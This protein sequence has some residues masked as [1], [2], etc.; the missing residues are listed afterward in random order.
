MKK[1]F[2]YLTMLASLLLMPAASTA[3]GNV[4]C[5]SGGA[6]GGTVPVLSQPRPLGH[7]AVLPLHVLPSQ[8]ARRAPTAATLL[9]PVQSRV[10]R[11]AVAAV[12]DLAGKKVMTYSTSSSSLGSGGGSSA[13]VTTATGDSIV[14]DG[15]YESGFKVK[16]AVDLSAK[17]VSIPVQTVASGISLGS[18]SGGTEVSSLYIAAQ[19]SGYAPDTAATIGGT[20]DDTGV[21]TLSKS[22]GIYVASGSFKNA[23][24]AL[25]SSAVIEPSNGTMHVTYYQDSAPAEDW[26][27]VIVQ[28][29][30]KAIAVKNFGNHGKT[31]NLVLND[32]GYFTVASQLAC[33]AGSAHGG[34]YYT[35]SIDDWGKGDKALRRNYITGKATPAEL[36]MGNWL[37]LSNSGYYTGK[38]ASA[39]IAYDNSAAKFTVPSL[40]VSGFNGTGTEADPYQVSVWDHLL[41]LSELANVGV[42]VDTLGAACAG[43]YYKLTADITAGTGL[44]PIGWPTKGYAFGG[45]FDG[46]NHT[47]SGLTMAS[48]EFSGLFGFI[49]KD[50]SVKNLNLAKVSIAGAGNYHGAVAGVTHGTIYNCHVAG[51]VA[52]TANGVGGIAGVVYGVAGRVE[53]C[54]FDGTVTGTNLLG[55]I[56]GQVYSDGAA[57][58][59]CNA[60]GT[61][62]FGRSRNSG[63]MAGGIAGIADQGSVV[64][65][66]YF[67]GTIKPST[68]RGSLL[69]GIAGK[70]Y[71]SAVVERCFAV[72]TIN[73]YYSAVGGVVG[74]LSATVRNCYAQGVITDENYFEG[75]K[76]TVGGLVGQMKG[77]IN[78]AGAY[79][80]AVL[81]NV[82]FT[83]EINV[84][85]PA[86]DGTLNTA[87]V[88]GQ[89]ADSLGNVY[90]DK[91]MVDLGSASHG[92]TTAQL[93]SAAGPAGFDAGVWNFTQGCYPRLKG[94][95]DNDVAKLS[96]SVLKIADGESVHRVAH[97]AAI[98]LL[99]STVAGL[100]GS[101]N[102]QGYAGSVVGNSY[103]VGSD[104]G[105]D[106]LYFKA[107]NGDKRVFH[108][109]VA[110]N[111]LK[112]NGTQSDPFLVTSKADL[113]KLGEATSEQAQPYADVYFSQTADID[114]DSDSTYVGLSAGSADLAF[115]GHY[116][117]N[118]HVVSNLALHG[119]YTGFVGVLGKR[120]TLSNLTAEG[121]PVAV[122]SHAAVLVGLN[123]GAVSNVCNRVDIT[124]SFGDVGA[125][126][127]YNT[128]AV[129]GAYNE[130]RV[131]G[132]AANVGGIVGS[133]DG[134]TL[135]YCQ[136][137]GYVAGS[138]AN[139]GGIA[140]R[141]SATAI[142]SVLNAGTVQGGAGAVGGIVGATVQ[143]SSNTAACTIDQALDYG[144]ELSADITTTG[145]VVGSEGQAVKISSSCYDAQ[146]SGL[147]AVANSAH[148]G[149]EAIAAS[150]LASGEAVAQLPVSD[151]AYTAGFYPVLKQHARHQGARAAQRV[152]VGMASGE[153]SRSLRTSSVLSQADSLAWKLAVDTMFSISGNRLN[154]PAQ[155]TVVTHDT[156][157]ATLGSYVKVIALAAVAAVPLEGE[158]TQASPYLIKTPAQWN[159]LSDYVAATGVSLTGKWVKVA[160]DL[161]FTGVDFKSLG[162]NGVTSFDAHLLGAGH[163][164]KGINL[165][166]TFNYA[167]AI[168]HLGASGSVSDLTLEGT[169]TSTGSQ[170]YIGAFAGIA[171][172]PFVNCVNKVNVTGATVGAAGF[173]ALAK[174]GVD[175]TRCHNEGNVTAPRGQVAGFVANSEATIHFTN[176]YNTGK[177]SATASGA[178]YV[179]GLL[180]RGYSSHFVRCYNTGEIV[181]STTG[182][183]VGGLYGS[184][185]SA[186]DTVRF[187]D[188]HNDGAVSG[189]SD[190][191]GLMGGT[192]YLSSVYD[193]TGALTKAPIYAAGCYNT[194]A[195]TAAYY[196]SESACAG[197]LGMV[198]PC[199]QVLDCYNTGAVTSTLVTGSRARYNLN[200]AGLV[201][202]SFVSGAAIYPVIKRCYNTGTVKGYV[203]VGGIMGDVDSY[204][205]VDSCYNTGTVSGLS[206]VGGIAGYASGQHGEI[207]NCYNTGDVDATRVAAGGAVGFSQLVLHVTNFYNTGHIVAQQCSGG[208]GGQS[209]VMASNCAN[210]GTVTAV[211]AAGGLVGACKNSYGY[212]QVYNSY[213]AGLI[214]CDSLA[215]ASSLIGDMNARNASVNLVSGSCYVT[216]F[217]HFDADSLGTPVTVREL[218][219][220]TSVNGNKAA[221][222]K[223]K[224]LADLPD[225]QP[226][227]LEDPASAGWDYGDDYT[228]PIV[229]GLEATDAAKAYAAAVVPAEGNSYDCVTANFNVGVPAGVTW[230][231]DTALVSIDG[232]NAVVAPGAV[233]K[234]TLTAHCGQY[235]HSWT[236]TLQVPTAVDGVDVA[237]H[238]VVSEMYFNLSGVQVAKPEA[239]D[240]QV[241]IVVRKY[242]NGATRAVKVKN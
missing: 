140:G 187:V 19:G 15:F 17:T 59:G 240:G 182:L 180:A 110:P 139:V 100:V 144:V 157:T 189:G 92:L 28:S 192:D 94:I 84:K 5:G 227:Y 203:Q 32:I 151:W 150:R 234:V 53:N 74:Q 106:E 196:S 222:S 26:N 107:P 220:A 152:I 66:S 170:Q 48:G 184:S 239:A 78:T 23:Y 129:T 224:Q 161:D 181:G 213:N 136:N 20:I 27:V 51:T 3:A 127:G 153:T 149:V 86:Y 24:V 229:K 81:D 41:Y 218:A 166:A 204:E 126:A 31:V 97:N 85:N 173:V 101:E 109:T 219:R 50:A 87:E 67:S 212:T 56:A 115:E 105:S 90:Y 114:M 207:I 158:G 30:P 118:G 103:E 143:G 154:V 216:D 102:T 232:N 7:V 121:S 172:G 21:I 178:G 169:A 49:S 174:D 202:R 12:S 130:A 111:F 25:V 221:A 68:G 138:S 95:D 186:P 42:D 62:S 96:G 159:A 209:S 147:S 29:A 89:C 57:V 119:H 122:D 132:A 163:T 108:V 77:Y 76:P 69:G 2:D 47:I 238:A 98:N 61:I 194:G 8:D 226:H 71:G 179:A 195:I 185:E 199:S 54:T 44:E 193:A 88:V 40:S 228:C 80:P 70:A 14:I 64:T 82:Y 188:C 73:G 91:Q 168:G 63:C 123:R 141:A 58:S 206:W 128:G 137:V 215:T 52:S 104:F 135:R 13:T 93:T 177:I 197:L 167:G 208:V 35:Y 116:D 75:Y 146:L 210:Y 165:V 236:V 112:G 242:D 217:N 55:G 231:L 83:G 205:L 211:E 22:F 233:G 131:K 18:S 37:M 160:T 124:S 191:A 145:T 175:F 4:D 190:V 79:V 125:I 241:Y 134:G 65:D 60:H 201:G 133:T 214:E 33:S 72:A 39:R 113:L 198:T 142:A 164:V 38:L 46:G 148:K 6:V 16:A 237:Q 117:G 171:E 223:V 34:D 162:G 99:G 230:T 36:T 235:S 9:A 11:K 10:P 225:A 200:T 183:Y 155:V 120:G 176:C 45:H 1:N 43:K 156:L